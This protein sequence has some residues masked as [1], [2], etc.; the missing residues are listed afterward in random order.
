MDLKISENTFSLSEEL[1]NVLLWDIVEDKS[2]N[3]CRRQLVEFMEKSA[4]WMWWFV[5]SQQLCVTESDTENAAGRNIIPWLLC[6]S[7]SSLETVGLE[8]A[9]A[10]SHPDSP[11]GLINIRLAQ[12]S[13]SLVCSFLAPRLPSAPS[14]NS[15]SNNCGPSYGP[16]PQV[17]RAAGWI[18]PWSSSQLSLAMG[19]LMREHNPKLLVTQPDFPRDGPAPWPFFSL[20]IQHS[21]TSHIRG[22]NKEVT[23]AVWGKGVADFKGNLTWESSFLNSTYK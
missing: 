17:P 3:G 21:R 16:W 10:C 14:C 8:Q 5:Y 22:K 18:E 9:G 15:F 19:L 13:H 2:V 20:R 1:G 23:K 4:L 7:H 12:S 11:S 6:F